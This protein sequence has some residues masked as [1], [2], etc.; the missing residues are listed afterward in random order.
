MGGGLHW[1]PLLEPY[2]FSAVHLHCDLESLAVGQK[3]FALFEHYLLKFKIRF[4]FV[5]VVYLLQ[6]V[7]LVN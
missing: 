7:N 4:T 5:V 2:E 6:K 3:L 1:K